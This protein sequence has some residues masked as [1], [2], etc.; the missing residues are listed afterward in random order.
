MP[1]RQ[2]TG[3]S[4]TICKNLPERPATL[5]KFTYFPSLGRQIFDILIFFCSMLNAQAGVESDLTVSFID[6][7]ST[8]TWEPSFQVSLNRLLR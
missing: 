6:G 5:G 3:S 8:A 1:K 7:L 2:L 4:P